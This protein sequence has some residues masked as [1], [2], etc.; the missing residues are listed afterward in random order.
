[1]GGRQWNLH[2][3]VSEKTH[4]CSPQMLAKRLFRKMGAN[5]T[6]IEFVHLILQAST[7][8]TS[9]MQ[10]CK[11]LRPM[12]T[13]IGAASLWSC[14][15]FIERELFVKLKGFIQRDLGKTDCFNA[16][17]FCRNCSTV[18]Q[19]MVCFYLFCPCHEIRP[20]LTDE[21]LQFIYE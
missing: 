11:N 21:N 20:A 13:N 12:R 1:M 2:V 8:D 14:P 16:D 9:M 7:Q 19:V 6:P 18:L 3:S 10:N 4:I 5:Y 17:G 15:A